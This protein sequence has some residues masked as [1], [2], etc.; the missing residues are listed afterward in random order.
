LSLRATSGYDPVTLASLDDFLALDLR[1]GTVLSAEVLRGARTPSLV[2][3]IDFGPL[4]VKS[5]SAPI[6]DLY[7]PAE[8]VGL[9]V[10]AVV[11]LPPREVAGLNSEALVLAV[12]NG[13]NEQ[14]LIMPERPAPDGSKVS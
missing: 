9:Q 3:T 13:R 8:L 5:T 14:V 4:G 2:L 11:N 1:V 7:S 10:V 6:T 12:D